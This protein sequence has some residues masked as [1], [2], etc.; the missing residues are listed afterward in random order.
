MKFTIAASVIG[1]LVAGTNA[2]MEMS[3]SPPFRSKSNPYSTNID[4]SM[5]NPLDQGGSNFPCKGYHSLIDTAEGASVATWTPG[6]DYSISVSGSATHNGGSCQLSLSYDKG[7]SWTVIHSFI[8]ACPLKENWDFT[9][10]SDAPSGSAIFAW[11]WWNNLGNR[12]M[13][14][15]CAHVTIGSNSSSASTPQ[16]DASFSSR[17]AMFVA[18]VGNGCS[19]VETYDV[20]FPNPGPDVTRSDGAKTTAP[21]GS[22]GGSSKRI[23]RSFSA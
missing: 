13:Y 18:N 15:N 8:G 19:T 22:C 23:A 7:S 3:N 6:Q 14:M 5:T 12:E 17:P 9:L 10:P 11:S 1:L 21:S 16:V 20:E 4:Y 2:H